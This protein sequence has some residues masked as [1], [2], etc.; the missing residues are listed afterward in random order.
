MNI[1]SNKNPVPDWSAPIVDRKG[2][3]EK[4]I[5]DEKKYY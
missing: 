1:G 5:K 2:V 3:L 4:T